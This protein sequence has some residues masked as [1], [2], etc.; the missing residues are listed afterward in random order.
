[1]LLW[2]EEN[3]RSPLLAWIVMSDQ[4]KSAE[5]TTT[6][7]AVGMSGH[8]L[9]PEFVSIAS[10]PLPLARPCCIGGGPGLQANDAAEAK[11]GQCRSRGFAMREMGEDSMLAGWP[12]ANEQ[13]RG[14]GRK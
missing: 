4:P 1:M 13:S 11:S 5:M 8:S 7:D 10:G 12:A 2:S 6:T 9:D 14:Y 3:P